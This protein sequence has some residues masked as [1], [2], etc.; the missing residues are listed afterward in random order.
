MIDPNL[1]ESDEMICERIRKMAEAEDGMLVSAGARPTHVA[2]VKRAGRVVELDFSEVPD[3]ARSEV[4]SE[5]RE[6]MGRARIVATN[7]VEAAAS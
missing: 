7:P 2:A 1:I 6:I 4:L 3:E 5:I